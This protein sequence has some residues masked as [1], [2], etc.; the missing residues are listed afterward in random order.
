MYIIWGHLWL[1]L[2]PSPY[3]HS[4]F[5]CGSRNGNRDW[6]TRLPLAGNTIDA[7][8]YGKKLESYIPPKTMATSY[9]T[10][11]TVQQGGL[12]LAIDCG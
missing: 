10:I 4:D 11:Y 2:R 9:N 8:V 7:T 3:F 5:R 6:G 12:V 1:S